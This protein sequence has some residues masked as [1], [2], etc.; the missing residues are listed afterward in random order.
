MITNTPWLKTIRQ[1]DDEAIASAAVRLAPMGRIDPEKLL[2]LHLDMN[3]Q[4]ISTI[5]SK[6]KAIAELAALGS[7][8]LRKLSVG[9]WRG[10]KD[11]IEFLG[12]ELPVGWFDPTR[13]RVAPARLAADGDD[14]WVRNVWLLTAM[15]CDIESGEALLDRCPQCFNRLT[16]ANIRHVWACQAC[17]FDLRLARPTYSPP[18]TISDAKTLA[19]FIFGKRERLP[20]PLEKLS[21]LDVLKLSAWFAFFK[22]IPE[23]LFLNV[24]AQNAAEGF[25]QLQKWPASFDETAVE[26]VGAGAN[27][28]LITRSIAAGKMLT[29]ID[30]LGSAE[31]RKVVRT[32][33]FELLDLSGLPN[34]AFRKVMEPVMGFHSSPARFEWSLSTTIDS[35]LSSQARTRSKPARSNT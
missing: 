15:R 34:E 9:A 5:A 14:A 18:E 25:A 32:R 20:P 30:R 33:L 8:D 23:R 1:F 4:S 12:C 3:G 7:F 27:E 17:S 31:A 10:Y 35:T 13:R 29:L 11:R 22:G 6:P 16:W 24:T 19:C 26:L 28:D 21:F 2:R